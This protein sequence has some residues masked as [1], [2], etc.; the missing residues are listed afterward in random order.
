M[1]LASEARAISLP[2][3]CGAETN[4]RWLAYELHCSVVS[5]QIKHRLSVKYEFQISNNSLHYKY[6]PKLQ[7]TYLIPKVQKFIFN[8]E[9]WLCFC[10]LNLTTLH[11]KPGSHYSSPSGFI[12]S[13]PFPRLYFLLTLHYILHLDCS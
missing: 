8:W 2:S 11:P 3:T 12:T 7:E 9:S 5:C 13:I 6:V 4:S 1:Q 10:F